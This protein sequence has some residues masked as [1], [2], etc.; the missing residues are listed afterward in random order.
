MKNLT[1][2]SFIA[3]GLLMSACT[4]EAEKPETTVRPTVPQASEWTPQPLQTVT[5]GNVGKA[6]SFATDLFRTV[7]KAEGGNLCVSPVS[8]FC[9]FAML[10]NGDTDE[11]RDE[12]L[13]F[14]GYGKGSGELHNLNVFCNSLLTEAAALNGPTQCTFT[15]SLWYH[16]A[17]TL[18]P[19]FE[20]DMQNIYD[21]YLFPVWLGDEEGRIAVNSFVKEHTSGMIE[22]FLSEPVNV[23]MA[24]MNTTYFKGSWQKSF[25]SGM[26]FENTFHNLDGTDS[27]TSYMFLN[28][29]IKY[30]E[31]DGIRG[32]CLPYAGD[33]Y[34]MTVLQP[35]SGSDFSEMLAVL[36]SDRLEELRSSFAPCNVIMQLPKFESQ[37]NIELL[38]CLK[39][40]GLD[41]AC[42]K[43][44][45]N[46][47]TDLY[48]L[49]F[50]KHAVKIIVDEEGTEA[51]AVSMAGMDNC[52]GPD[53]SVLM[54]FDSPFIYIIQDTISETV[55][56]M[57]AITEF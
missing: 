22:E 39:E 37:V 27:R 51:A 55:L 41:K 19:E 38:E 42:Y 4:D 52:V 11:T 31:S 1:Y 50:F 32:V 47:G 56:F 54:T 30:G 6:N 29:E 12:V 5:K 25:D 43:G 3:L 7:F 45:N 48:V 15:S 18:L 44:F 9:T 23:P 14:L 46:I 35:S 49:V 53:E 17:V 57:G 8:I 2:M 28:E 34:T 10:A 16:P 20:A 13:N 24:F 33:R 36:N 26:T 40:M 21:A